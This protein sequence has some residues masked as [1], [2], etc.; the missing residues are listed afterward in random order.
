[1]S[2]VIRSGSVAFRPRARLLKLIGAELI[3]DEVVAVTELVKNAYDADASRVV[4]SFRNVTTP[5]GEIT[6]SDDGV[7]MDLVTVLG[8]WMEP[9]AT[10]KGNGACRTDGRRRRVLGEKGVGRFAAD[11]LGR[12]LELVSR[13]GGEPAEVRATFDFDLFDS[14]TEMLGAIRSRWELR[15]AATI[16]RRGTLLRISG[17]RTAWTERMFRRLATRLA[18]LCSP[19][20]QLDGFA[21]RLE[22]DEFPDYAGEL[23]GGFLEQAPYRIE[24][25][26]DG[27]DTMEIRLRG[28]GRSS[29]AWVDPRP[30]RCGRVRALIFAFD[31][32]TDALARIGP[33]IEVRAWLRE[34]S[35]VSVYRDGFRVWPYG[36][37]HDDWLR[38]DQRRVNNPVVR[39]SNNQ[40]VSFVEISRDRNPDLRDQTSREGL[41]HNEAFEDL[42]RF[43]HLVLEIL[44]GDR[45][46]IRH[47]G[48]DQD[49]ATP[50]A[51]SI[52][53][54]NGNGHAPGA[55]AGGGLPARHAEGWSELAAA[56][57]AAALVSRALLPLAGEIQA[58][59]ARIRQDLNGG[60]G[61]EAGR[62]LGRLE[63]HSRELGQRLEAIVA[64]HPQFRGS[65]RTIDV[66]VELARVRELLRPLLE[67]TGVA[68]KVSVRGAKLLR[69]E[70]RVESFQHL[71]CILVR[72]ALDWLQG[73]RRPV[74]RVTGR[75]RGDKCEVI[76]ADNGPGIRGR[77]AGQVFDPLFSSREGGHGMGLAVARALIEVHGGEISALHDRRRGGAAFRILLP[78]KRARSTVSGR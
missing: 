42:R 13:R 53:G 2:T 60:G 59:V 43:I 78:R 21:I 69:V 62:L 17:L 19:F 28:E 34:W 14:G 48:S 46:A 31:L 73:R 8:V 10:S 75:P 51:R 3:S 57:Q 50:P 76:V 47:P 16:E 11:K 33:R 67:A 20:G 44:E 70:M 71:L 55:V 29:R 66:A 54:R 24:A 1:V 36:E 23:A 4:I 45:Q 38:L 49:R 15:P 63:E 61:S 9:G 52:S 72:N 37:P 35:G 74:I 5:G 32:E 65:R 30:L 58:G 22:S 26:F 6:V 64:M 56:G 39:L 27:E 18:R 12:H 7:G 41:L 77:V 68:M 25:T 40:V